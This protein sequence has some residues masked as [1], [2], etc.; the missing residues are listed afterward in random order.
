MLDLYGLTDAAQRD[1][2]TDLAREARQRGWWHTYSDVLPNPHSTFIGLEAEAASIRTYQA[3]LVPG[4]LQTEDYT[5]A[6]VQATRMTITD[7][8]EARRFVE[9]R[10]ARQELLTAD[11]AVT[12][13]AVLDEA[14]LRRRIGGPAVMTAQLH[15]LAEAAALPQVT[16]Q[17]LPAAA[18][19]HVALEGSFMIL[20]F[21]APGEQDVVYIDATTGGVY[22]EKAEDVARYAA[23]FDHVRAAALSPRE[24]VTFLQDT[25]RQMRPDHGDGKGDPV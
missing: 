20:G 6:V 17:V 18:G 25:A 21:A 11:P 1:P 9:V 10:Q 19:E 15:R 12:L 22:A 2:L 24:S 13:W 14:V 5:R 8:D 16:L 4:L 3:Q 23:V 7:T